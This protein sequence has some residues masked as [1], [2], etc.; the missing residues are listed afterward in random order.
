MWRAV[1]LALLLAAA[2]AA[3]AGAAVR[4]VAPPGASE[5]DQY[6]E[7]LP[8]STGPRAPDAAKKARDAFRD[9]ALT[10]AAEGALRRR[11]PR[12]LKLA[13]AVAQ[14]APAGGPR[15]SGPPGEPA[16]GPRGEGGLGAL[17][18]L[19]L[20]ATAAAALAFALARRRPVA[21]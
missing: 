5:A 14:T 17:F 8:S 12:G 19:V 16:V 18:P 7:T 10:E 11:G 13:T 21:R 20:A 6:F 15:G 4:V 3:P 2:L 1:T 9:G